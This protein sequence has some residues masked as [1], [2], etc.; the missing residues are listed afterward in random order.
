MGSDYLR[1]E[2]LGLHFVRERIVST[3]YKIRA[4]GEE[5]SGKQVYQYSCGQECC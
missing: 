4:G 5:V 3:E 1:A 2:M